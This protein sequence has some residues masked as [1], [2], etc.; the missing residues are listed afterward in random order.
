MFEILEAYNQWEKATYRYHA[1]EEEARTVHLYSVCTRTL[2]MFSTPVTY[3]QL[4]DRLNA[5]EEEKWHIEFGMNRQYF[6]SLEAAI[7]FIKSQE[8]EKLR[9]F[10]KK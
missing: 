4:C 6:P 5:P 9:D 1:I 7:D 3:E 10:C 2:E 8:M